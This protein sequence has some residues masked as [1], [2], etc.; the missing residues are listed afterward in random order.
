M[1]ITIIEYLNSLFNNVHWWRRG[2][3][4]WS[5]GRTT[6]WFSLCKNSFSCVSTAG[7]WLELFQTSVL[8]KSLK[9]LRNR[10]N[11]GPWGWS[12]ILCLWAWA[13][14]KRAK[15]STRLTDAFWDW[16]LEMATSLLCF[17]GQ[18]PGK[19]KER[20]RV[21][22]LIFNSCVSHVFMK[23]QDLGSSLMV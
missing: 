22:S 21:C 13:S 10:W 11:W 6:S 8:N 14:P 1:E 17:W 5:T 7:L 12:Q 19:H 3:S 15:L 4:K 2:N 16:F 23:C 18:D 20:N 9:N